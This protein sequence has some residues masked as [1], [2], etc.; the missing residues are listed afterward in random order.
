MSKAMKNK[1]YDRSRNR[2]LSEA[3]GCKYE[4]WGKSD[5]FS[6][7]IHPKGFKVFLSPSQIEKSDEYSEDDPYTVEENIDSEFHKRRV[8]ATIYLLK[9]ALDESIS[10]PKILDMGCGEGY[11]TAEIQK[12]FLDAEIS[13]LDYSISA[14]N[15]AVENFPGIDFCVADAHNPPYCDNYFDVVVLNNLWEHIPDP[16]VLLKGISRILKDRGYLILST[17]SRYHLSNLLNVLRGRQAVFMSNHHVT[18]Y[19]VGQVIEQLRWGGIEVK[20]VYS[21][22]ICNR[23]KGIKSMIAYQVIL[24]ILRTYLKMI[25]S[26]HSLESTV[27]FLAEKK[28]I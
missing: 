3:D 27:F 19:S 15:Y 9:L 23:S 25:N 17:P 24:P 20:K 10:S 26:H 7:A 11:I 12:T 4:D 21:K 1:Y 14:I 6:F 28:K 5:D 18:E 8:D 16:L 2:F 22:P 13:G